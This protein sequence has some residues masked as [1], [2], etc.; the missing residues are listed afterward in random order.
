LKRMYVTIS[1]CLRTLGNQPMLFKMQKMVK[2]LCLFVLLIHASNSVCNCT[3]LHCCALLSPHES[4]WAELYHCG[5]TSSFLT[6]TGMTRQAFTNLHHVQFVGQQPQRTGRPQLMDPTAQLGLFLFC[7]RR[8]MGYK[9]LCLISGCA[10]TVCS[11]V[12]NKMLKP[13]V[14]KL[15]RHPLARVQFPDAEQMEYY[16]HLIHEQELAVDDVVGFMDGVTLTSESISEPVVQN[17]MYCG[18]QS[19]TMVNNLCAYA[20]DGK[21][22]FCA[23]NFP[24]S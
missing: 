24:G 2:Y 19:D 4:P 6:M 1:L 22:I 3:K 14:K 12:I 18:Y 17:S 9:H 7:I 5:D 10:P 8:T 23:I 21:V 20:P 15:R 13:V 11:R 16:V